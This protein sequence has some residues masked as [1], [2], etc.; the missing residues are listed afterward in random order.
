VP[1]DDEVPS[2]QTHAEYVVEASDGTRYRVRIGRTGVPRYNPSGGAVNLIRGAMGLARRVLGR[3]RDWTV[4]VVPSSPWRV[5][6]D[7][8]LEEDYP[9]RAT[10]VDRATRVARSLIDG[11]LSF[12]GPWR[13][14][15]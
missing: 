15:R 11:T 1:A 14:N 9:D 10:A 8:V 4:E 2:F 7:P 13:K 3:R 12:D 6:Y 5:F